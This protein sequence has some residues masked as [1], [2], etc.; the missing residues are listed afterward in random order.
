MAGLILLFQIFYFR[1][2]IIIVTVGAF[3]GLIWL[4][5]LL[6][7]IGPQASRPVFIQQLLDAQSQRGFAEGAGLSDQEEVEENIEREAV[8]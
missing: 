7:Y 5:V 4:P 1:M 3:H 2:Y 6:S 8:L